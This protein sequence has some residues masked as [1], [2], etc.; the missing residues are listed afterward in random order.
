[1]NY[2]SGI[3]TVQTMTH[4]LIP[5]LTPFV[6]FPFVPGPP[7]LQTAGFTDLHWP[8][9][10]SCAITEDLQVMSSNPDS[11]NFHTKLVFLTC[12]RTCDGNEPEEL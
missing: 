4:A 9:G 10:I 1:M 5:V 3:K 7:E 6:K 8:G 2:L 12:F 11:A